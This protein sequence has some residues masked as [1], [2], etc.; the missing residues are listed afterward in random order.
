MQQNNVTNVNEWQ[1]GVGPRIVLASQSPRRK[2]LLAAMSVEFETIPSA[3]DEYLDDARDPELVAKELALGKALDVAKAHP[4]AFVIGSDTIVTVDGHQLGKPDSAVAAHDMLKSLAGKPN[5]VTT[6][7]AV[8]CLARNV[9]ITDAA[10]AT[11]FFKEYDKSSVDAYVATGDPMD[12]AGGYAIQHPLCENMIEK[13]EGDHDIIVGFPTK[14]VASLLNQC[15]LKA[16]ALEG[17]ELL[18]ALG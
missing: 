18:G 2:Q 15:G 13:I 9:R 4:D 10:T 5:Y 6:G 1:S 17:E 3:F 16:K 12:K 14:V 11:V 8:V 7:V